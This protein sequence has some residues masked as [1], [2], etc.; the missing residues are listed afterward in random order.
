VDSYQWL[1]NGVAYE[2]ATRST[3][4]LT[5]A[6][7]G[8]NVSVK[9]SAGN[10]EGSLVSASV[11]VDKLSGDAPSAPQVVTVTATTVTLA[12]INNAEYS[13]GGTV[14]Q[15][16]PKFV[17]LDPN[18]EYSF[19]ARY[20]ASSTTDASEASPATVQRTQKAKLEGTPVLVAQD[21][22]LTAPKVGDVLTI[23]VTSMTSDPQV[24][25]G[26][27]SYQWVRGCQ[28]VPGA[29]GLTYT[30]SAADVDSVISVM[31]STQNTLGAVYSGVSK[32]VLKAP[33][34]DAPAAPQISSVG[35]VSVALVEHTGYEYSM[36]QS[37]W[38]RSSLVRN[39]APNQNYTFYQRVAETPSNFASPA[40]AGTAATTNKAQLVG[41]VGINGTLAVGSELEAVA[42]LGGK[43]E[44][45]ESELG[46]LSY[47]WMRDGIAIDL[48]TSNTYTL[49]PADIGA[50]ITV[51]VSAANCDGLV[52]SKP[53]SAVEK[54]PYTGPAPKAPVVASV[55]T[56]SV[57][58]TEIA[59]MEYARSDLASS[60]VNEDTWQAS[61][62][63]SGLAPNSAYNFYARYPETE[64][65]AASDPSAP[66]SVKT[67]KSTQDPPKSG[68]EVASLT[69]TTVTLKKMD[70]AEYTWNNENSAPAEDDDMW[71][72]D[73]FFEGLEPN[74]LYFFFAR[75]AATASSEP[76]LA[77]AGTPVMTDKAIIGGEVVVTGGNFPGDK[78]VASEDSISVKA[79]GESLGSRDELDAQYQWLR[80]GVPIPGATDST[81]TLTD[82]DVNHAIS[83]QVSYGGVSGTVESRDVRVLP[84][85]DTEVVSAEIVQNPCGSSEAQI[86]VVTDD[87]AAKVLYGSVATDGSFTASGLDE[88]MNWVKFTVVAQ[89]GVTQKQ[90]SISVERR[91]HL[92]SATIMV[93]GKVR[94]LREDYHNLGFT[95]WEW[96]RNGVA[97]STA[98]YVGVNDGATY[99]LTIKGAGNKTYHTCPDWSDVTPIEVLPPVVNATGDLKVYDIKGNFVGT[100]TQNLV[101]GVYIVR[102]GSIT[103]TM[104]AR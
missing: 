6:L 21:G 50:K 83:V 40:S 81:Y 95:T 66:T 20:A 90:D 79:D 33:A 76:S 88:G 53:G 17:G 68:P 19:Y 30:L 8:Q 101:P 48:A 10:C 31:V 34:P 29:D 78:L 70:G 2:G 25:L 82:A 14:W 36:D 67:K 86:R 62:L 92:D 41:S 51:Q 103:Q 87:P 77:S 16:S 13:L 65:T 98:T 52:V 89:D 99:S 1:E 18:T 37:T 61:G 47:Q 5:N 84:L 39:L 85:N 102:Q 11:A 57:Q 96:F 60:A 75:Y 44:V 27:F 23:D 42:V 46:T 32:P 7:A 72:T 94:A 97:F 74:T 38:Q 69:A 49:T 43:P 73:T 56:S 80:D 9:V 58:V 91:I 35:P 12:L 45:E 54:Q 24:A 3:L 63:F 26:V 104:V 100:S 15:A 93:Q 55:S 64:V 22:D 59:G 4:V 71:Q 28:N